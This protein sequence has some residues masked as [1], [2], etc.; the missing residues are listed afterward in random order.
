MTDKKQYTHYFVPRE[1]HEFAVAHNGTGLHFWC[2]RMPDVTG[3]TEREW[4]GGIE[5]HW[6]NCPP[7]ATDRGPDHE[8]CWVLD[9]PCWH[10]G[11]SLQAEEIWIPRWLY[12]PSDHEGILNLLWGR[13]MSQIEGDLATQTKQLMPPLPRTLCKD[14]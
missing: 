3:F 6:S 5:V 10:D 7:W 11:S 8:H 2:E 4:F 12:D 9:G 14:Q 1:R 13:L